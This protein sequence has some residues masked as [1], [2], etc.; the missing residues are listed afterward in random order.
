MKNRARGIQ[1]GVSAAL[2]VASTVP[3]R[4]ELEWSLDAGASHT[5]NA[6]LADQNASEDTLASFGGSIDFDHESR[7]LQAALTGH[8]NYVH[9]LDDTF[10]DDFQSYAS[11]N[12]VFGVVP[13]TFLW[14]LDDTYGQIA[15]NQFE[16][17]TPDNRQDVNNFSTG[18]DVLLRAGT[19][20]SVRLSG[21]YGT[22]TYEETDSIDSETLHASVSFERR[23]SESASWALVA[24][25][26][27]VKYDAPGDPEYD[28]PS[29]YGSLQ[30]EGGRQSFTIDV[31]ATQVDAEGE[32]ET[33]PLVRVALNRRIASSWTM[34]LHLRSEYQNTSEQFVSQNLLR[35]TDT[36]EVGI[37]DAPAAA[38]EGGVSF[39]FQRSRTRFEIE[40]GY[41]RLDYI[42]DNGLNEKTWYAGA[43][44]TRRHTPQLEGFFNYRLV[45]HEYDD[46]P[47]RDDTRHRAE[48][49]LDWRVGR[50][51]FLTGGYQYTDVDSDSATNRYTVNL[52][53]LTLSYRHAPNAGSQPVDN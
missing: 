32:K 39:S 51:V 7:R 23:L 33:K 42:V 45:K 46:N 2:L 20:S 53:F 43:G 15:I 11:G 19:Q 6:T 3:V 25:S 16:P 13:E 29:I 35:N 34:D 48:L 28:Q 1:V 24:A 17:V 27:R 14:T 41:S 36:A 8:G 49:G 26:N 31:G 4:A 38:Y 47:L 37:S 10:D 40:S 5:D 30:S 44:I 18:P 52:F 12:L 50:N 9:Y 21:R 22:S